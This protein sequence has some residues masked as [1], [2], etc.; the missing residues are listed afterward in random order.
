[1]NR[2]VL[3]IGGTGQTGQ[4]IVRQL[5][6]AGFTPMVLARD[7]ERARQMLGEGVELWGGDIT[8]PESVAAAMAS[9]DAVVIVVESSTSDQAANSPERVHEQGARHVLAA[10]S[11]RQVQVIL[12]SQIYITRPERYP[13]VRNIIH[14]RG[15]AEAA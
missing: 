1:M 12:V 2:R 11:G 9:A 10:A 14:W 7:I 6:P 8:R 15:Q 13:E 4:H 3:V 5:P